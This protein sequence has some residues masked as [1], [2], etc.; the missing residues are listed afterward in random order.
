MSESEYINLCEIAWRRPLTAEEKAGLESY[1]L[2][3]PEAQTDWE[4]EML[5]KQLVLTLPDVP[6]SSNFTA[7]VLQT[8]ELEELQ[9]RRTLESAPWFRRIRLWLPRLA[10]AGLVIGLGGLS[11][12]QY[13]LHSLREKAGAVKMVTGIAST[14]PDMQMWQDFDAIAKLSQPTA[15]QDEIL[16]KALDSSSSA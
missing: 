11:Y 9:A 13:H 15:S 1:L 4:E 7:R 6:V 3:H 12:Q 14:L 2:V 10:V 8:V 16:W 5:L